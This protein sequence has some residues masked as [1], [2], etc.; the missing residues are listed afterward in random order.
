MEGDYI[1]AI[2][3]NNQLL[4]TGSEDT[5]G[6][7]ALYQMLAEA[8]NLLQSLPPVLIEKDESGW[9]RY[10]PPLLHPL[11]PLLRQLETAYLSDIYGSQKA[12]LLSSMDVESLPILDYE[13]RESEDTVHT[14]TVIPQVQ[15]AL[16]PETDYVKFVSYSDGHGPDDGH[17]GAMNTLASA[18]FERVK[19]V[20]GD[21]LVDVD[22][23]P[24]RYLMRAYPT[25]A[26]LSA[27]GQLW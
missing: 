23:Y 21:N 7:T 15:H 18:T 17:G 2:P 22:Q 4:I 13:K 3:D 10:A 25:P 27:I 20:M 24:V 5:R 16:V 1:I 26:E 12:L 19:E 14:W 6:L 11:N 8:Q 9:R